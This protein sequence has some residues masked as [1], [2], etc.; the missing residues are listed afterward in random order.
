MHPYRTHPT[1]IPRTGTGI[2]GGN[3][4][5]FKYNAPRLP[6]G[7]PEPHLMGLYQRA[8]VYTPAPEFN[9]R[10]RQMKEPADTVVL[11]ES[12]AAC[13]RAL[14]DGKEKKTAI[15]VKAKLDLRKTA[16]ALETLERLYLAG[17]SGRHG[18]RMTGRGRT[19]P[20]TV[21]PD[22]KRR[23]GGGDS[24]SPGSGAERLLDALDRPMRGADL[25]D[26]LGVSIQRI[27]QLVV[28]SLAHG[29]LRVGDEEKVLEIVARIDDPTILLSRDEVRILSVVPVDYATSAAKIEAAA[30]ISV[31]RA[32]AILEGLRGNG[33]VEENAE[34]RDAPL[35]RVAAAGLAHPQRRGSVARA[36]RLPAP[37]RSDRVFAVLSHIAACDRARIR[38]AGD[39]LGIPRKSMNALMQYLKRKSLV[40]KTGRELAAPYA[41]TDEGREALTEMTRRRAA[42]T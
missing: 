13:L 34:A 42:S 16:A 15:A 36:D 10:K 24:G 28:K 35:Y 38:E 19:C 23:S 37:V 5:A 39:A 3:P 8:L 31:E 18:W 33:L 27:R 14:A 21:V 11:T 22:R 30:A 26:R 25:A 17:R 40:R 6:G 7:P 2:A 9:A 4:T 32:K 20:L 41:L 1:L 12:Q 29:R